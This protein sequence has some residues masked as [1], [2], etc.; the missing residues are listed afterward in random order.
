MRQG[1]DALAPAGQRNPASQAL[2]RRRV[3]TAAAPK[4]A[5]VPDDSDEG[6]SDDSTKSEALMAVAQELMT[7]TTK[8]KR[9]KDSD[10]MKH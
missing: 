4:F 1:L 7:K 8:A 2:S 6:L 10:N 3:D 9:G 5:H